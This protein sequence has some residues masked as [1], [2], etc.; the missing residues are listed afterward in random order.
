L[1]KVWLAAALFLPNAAVAECLGQGCYDGIGVLIGGALAV[2][3]GLCITLI[4]LL[5]KQMF[6]AALILI[7]ICVAAGFIAAFL[8]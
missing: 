6:T 7:G 2:V 1:K 5:V 8:V 3:L 4:V